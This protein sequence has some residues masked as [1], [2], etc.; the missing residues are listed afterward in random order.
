MHTQVGEIVGGLQII[1]ADENDLDELEKQVT[2]IA[3]D[4][5]TIGRRG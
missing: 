5:Q 3:N 1:N 2:N 4:L